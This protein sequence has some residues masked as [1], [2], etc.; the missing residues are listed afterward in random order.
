MRRGVDRQGKEELPLGESLNSNRRTGRGQLSERCAKTPTHKQCC[1]RYCRQTR[2]CS[3]SLKR[4]EI[5]RPQG[6]YSLI[7][8]CVRMN[9]CGL[10]GHME[11][12]RTFVILSSARHF[13]KNATW[14]GVRA[15]MPSALAYLYQDRFCTL[16]GRS[17]YPTGYKGGGEVAERTVVRVERRDSERRITMLDAR[18]KKG[19]R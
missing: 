17:V 8:P 6:P 16:R 2:P 14:S 12:K 11:D 15:D 7:I 9:Y 18:R 13:S 5:S 19:G 4:V 1:T 10:L 3:V